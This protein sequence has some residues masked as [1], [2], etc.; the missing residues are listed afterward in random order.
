LAALDT[1]LADARAGCAVCVLEGMPGIGKTTIWRAGVDLARQ[2]GAT[3]LTT[4]ATETEASLSLAGLGDL[5][6]A[7]GPDLLAQLPGPQADA[8]AGAL[9]RSSLPA[10]GVDERA[11]FAS[12]LSVLR[13]M[14]A[15]GPVVV[16]VDDAQ[17]LDVATARALAFAVRR[18]DH[19]PVGFLV[20]VRDEGAPVP[21]FDRA[22]P[23]R[24]R[25]LSVG[26]LS[27]AALHEVVVQATGH[28]L[29]RPAAV[30]VATACAGNPL[31]AIEIVA[32]MQRRGFER[33]DV[34]V[35][36]SLA[37]L[38]E[39]RVRRLPARTQRALLTAAALSRP[40]TRLVDARPL[41]PAEAAGIVELDRGRVRFVH[42]MFAS[43]VYG[44]ADPASRR[45][46]HLHLAQAVA[47]P[48]EQA[49][50]LALAATAPDEVIA[51]RLDD[52]ASIVAARGAPDAAAELV[53]L[54]IRS[55]DPAAVDAVSRRR[56]VGARYRLDAGDLAGAEAMLR[57][58][59]VEEGT[60]TT[61]ADARR[62]LCLLHGR[63]SDF[64]DAL[65][66]ATDAL[67]M[68][69]DD[70][71]LR[72]EIELDVAFCH[73][74]LGDFGAAQ[75]FARKA[76]SSAE[77]VATGTLAE[78]LAALTI[79]EY[80]GGRGLDEARLARALALENPTRS[81]AFT[82]RPSYIRSALLL[83]TGRCE[84][85]IGVLDALRAET[86]ERG[87]ESAI[88]FLAPYRVWAAVWRGDLTDAA[89]VVDDTRDSARLVGD[90]AAE[91]IA[92]GFDA[93]LHAFTGPLERVHEQA[94]RSLELF[95]GLQWMAGTIWPLWAI[96][97]ATLAVGDAQMVD[98][99]LG[100][101]AQMMTGMES[102]DPVLAVFLPEEVEA[103]VDLGR[104]D[105]AETFTGWLTRRAEQ[106]DSAWGIA[107]GCRCRGL[108]AAASGAHDE[109]VACLQE[110]A[111]RYEALG[112][113]IER[114]RTEVALG[115]VHRRGKQKRLARSSLERALDTFD[116]TGA[117]LWAERARVELARVTTRRAATTLTNTERRIAELAADGLT[118]REIA[119]RVFVSPKTV[120]A[121]L[122]R[123]YRKLG[124]SSRAQLGRALDGDDST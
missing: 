68:V 32:E 36:P 48:E 15:E 99:T 117:A 77:T 70:E 33:R 66:V 35:P 38:I 16:A 119:E 111:D 90:P 57:Q 92:S 34:P 11:L 12:V 58:V 61:G 13:A 50:H 31:H 67:A 37:A 83:W 56:V 6:G 14:S 42:P 121:N 81:T 118:N 4:R 101:L 85:A 18:L 59:I 17:W 110:A 94:Q 75:D 113:P 64:A 73:A 109:A 60:G 28:S 107:A 43:A 95:G 62:L 112:L 124:L 80:L 41:E 39:E 29:A 25:S 76:V 24:R 20:A 89:R 19:E 51:G 8:F 106:V 97:L 54:A 105:E 45:R 91:A 65:A 120:E 78:A 3:V 115:R 2:A 116:A 23:E 104:I 26:P 53:D 30:R 7:V 87:E 84:E 114:A 123:V 72:T 86:L 46:V 44:S 96:G 88:P 9:L 69:E 63:R 40:T 5:F 47:E 71:V 122:G 102:I 103:L 49:L 52:A 98:A 22:D 79:S 10:N 93:L 82:M 74:S 108:V 27:V 55:S 100:P 21:S 1:F